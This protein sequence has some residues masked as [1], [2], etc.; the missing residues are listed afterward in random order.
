[1]HCHRNPA[2]ITVGEGDE[3]LDPRIAGRYVALE[4][5]SNAIDGT[6]RLGKPTAFIRQ[7]GARR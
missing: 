1:M 2:S 5:S 6:F 7:G 3:L 4:F